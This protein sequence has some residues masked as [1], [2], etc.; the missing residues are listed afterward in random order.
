MKITANTVLKLLASKH[1]AD[2]FVPE[3]KTGPTWFNN[4]LR[5]L[6]AWVLRRSWTNF[7]SIGYEI[8]VSRS[9][10]LADTK[11]PEYMDFCHEF[12]FVCPWGLIVPDDIADERVGLQYVSKNAKRIITKRKASFREI[13]LNEALVAHILISRVIVIRPQEFLQEISG[14]IRWMNRRLEEALEGTT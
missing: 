7:G 11:W 6:D 3:C 9:D 8:K 2:V 4:N 12:Y 10:F 5:K 1:A 14:P 13:Q